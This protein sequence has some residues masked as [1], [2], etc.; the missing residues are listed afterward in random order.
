MVRLISGLRTRFGVVSL[1]TS[2][3]VI[4]S[5]F[6][7]STV[8]S[9][10]APPPPDEEVVT[11]PV[12]TGSMI[13]IT[14]NT[15]A[16][17]PWTLYSQQ[18]DFGWCTYVDLTQ[19]E[20]CGS[21][22]IGESALASDYISP[23]YDRQYSH[24]VVDASAPD[25]SEK[26][27]TFIYGPVAK[28]VSGLALMI[29]GDLIPIDIIRGPQGTATDFFVKAWPEIVVI[30]SILAFDAAGTVLQKVRFTTH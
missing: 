6:V 25:P 7:A 20:G 27:L 23:N 26:G 19:G 28:P 9:N 24:A 30:D 29:D 18:S 14:S 16:G 1:L 17:S 8:T 15:L 12:Y 2:I 22:V 4:A 11:E 3:T 13:P 21:G 10:A 5:I